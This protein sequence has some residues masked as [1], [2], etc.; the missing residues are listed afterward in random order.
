VAR[1][2][3]RGRLELTWTNKDECLLATEDGGYE[4][5]PA[6]D[7]R[8]A[9]VRLLHSA[10]QEGELKSKRAA[11][12]LLIRGDALNALMSLTTLPEFKKQLLGKVKLIYIDPPFNTQ[13]AFEHYDD[14]LEHSVWLTMMRDRLQLLKK[15]LHRDGVIW[16]HVDDDEH[17]YLKVLMDEEF[18]RGRFVATVIWRKVD[19]SRN[20]ADQFSRDHDTLV[21]YSR[22]PGWEPEEQERPRKLTRTTPTRTTTRTAIGTAAATG[23]HP[24]RVRTCATS[25]STGGPGRWTSLPRRTLPSSSHRRTAGDGRSSG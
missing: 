2:R 3:Y 18:G 14:A 11:D 12:N 4:W 10:G 25:S 21:V 1:R 5:T 19:S 23:H 9:E 17:A 7:H 16:V 20:D 13:Q 8:V 15:L 24:N 6:S 22:N